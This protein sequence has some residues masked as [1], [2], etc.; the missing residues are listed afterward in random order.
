M[1]R[2]KIWFEGQWLWFTS[3]NEDESEAEEEVIDQAVDF[4]SKKYPH[5]DVNDSLLLVDD[6]EYIGDQKILT[7]TYG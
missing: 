2:A 4:Y 1:W 5:L 7:S 3:E 6:L